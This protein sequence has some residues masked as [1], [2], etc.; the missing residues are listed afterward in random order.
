MAGG[1]NCAWVGSGFEGLLSRAGLGAISFPVSIGFRTNLAGVVFPALVALLAN[2]H[3]EKVPADPNVQEEVWRG[4]LV[5]YMTRPLPDGRS[6]VLILDG[7][8]EAAD[9]AADPGLF[10]PN[11]PPGLRLVLSARHLANDRDTDAWF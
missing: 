10:P 1:G 8:D 9:W 11:P 4:L 5:D 3:G 7:V 6:L 2:F